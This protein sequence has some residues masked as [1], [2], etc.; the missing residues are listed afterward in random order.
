MSYLKRF[1]ALAAASRKTTAEN[2]KVGRDKEHQYRVGIMRPDVSCADGIDFKNYILAVYNRLFDLRFQRAVIVA[3]SF[4]VFDESVGF[5]KRLELFAR[6]EVII[7]TVDLTARGLLDVADTEYTI[8]SL[9]LNTSFNTVPLP[10]PDGPD[11]TKN[12]P[13]FI[14]FPPCLLPCRLSFP[15]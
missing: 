3:V 10:E 9:F 7:D 4:G 15:A 14:R 5:Y 6:F 2:F 13:F 12:V 1:G 8:L 11:N